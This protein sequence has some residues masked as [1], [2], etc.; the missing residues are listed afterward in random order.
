MDTIA[1]YI[2]YIVI[3][4]IALVLICLSL[5]TLYATAVGLFRIIEYKQTSRF[6]KKYEPR[7]MYKTCKVA[8]EFLIS[9]GLHKDNTLEEALIKIERFGKR[10]KIKENE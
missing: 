4:L 9:K 2:G 10:F 5:L 7:A 8:V 6:I 3:G 1:L